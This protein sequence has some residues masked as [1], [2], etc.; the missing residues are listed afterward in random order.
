MYISIGKVSQLL[1]TSIS[2]LRRWDLTNIL[3]PAFC[4][5]GGHRR[6]H[7]PTILEMRGEATSPPSRPK[8]VAYARVSG[9]KQKGDLQRQITS[10]RKYASKHDMELTRI[11]IASG[12]NDRRRQFLQML[13]HIPVLRPDAILITYQDRLSRFGTAVIQLL[14]HM[15]GTRIIC[16]CQPKNEDSQTQLVN[17]VIEVI[18]SYAGR[19]HRQRRRSIPT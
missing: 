1:G 12:I 3:K 10:I 6:Y 17:G 16:I 4:T 7:L 5:L 15:F 8:V 14:C 19:L 11:Y 18:T 13:Q 2:T 9:H